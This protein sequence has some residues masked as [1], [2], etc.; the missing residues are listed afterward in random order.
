MSSPSGAVHRPS[1]A[2]L[3]ISGAMFVIADAPAHEVAGN[4]PSAVARGLSHSGCRAALTG[5]LG[6]DHQRLSAAG[7]PVEPTDARLCRGRSPDSVVSHGGPAAERD[8]QSGHR[9]HASDAARLGSAAAGG[10]WPRRGLTL[11]PGKRAR[12]RFDDEDWEDR[13]DGDDDAH[14]PAGAWL[15]SFVRCQYHLSPTPADSRFARPETLAARFP[16]RQLLRC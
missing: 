5:S 3:A 13:I 8:S 1:I 2:L 11:R 15:Q 10:A 9:V 14:V 16:T 12:L 6:L 7:R 4:V